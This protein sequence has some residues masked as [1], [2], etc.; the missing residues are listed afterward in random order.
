MSATL[1]ERDPH[2]RTPLLRRI[3]IMF[4]HQGIWFHTLFILACVLGVILNLIRCFDFSAMVRSAYGPVGH[5]TPHDRWVYLLT[6]IGWPPV[7]WLL[8]IL[9]CWIPIE[10]MLNPPDEITLEEASE[11]DEKT[12]VYHPRASMVGPKRDRLGRLTDHLVVVTGAYAVVCFV[13]SW[14]V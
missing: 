11:F 8:Q 12:G 14:Y 2:N 6:R 13:G 7:Y 10:Y 1:S 9:S 5:L 3:R 4:F